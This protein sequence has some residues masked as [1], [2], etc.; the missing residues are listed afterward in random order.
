MTNE[1]AQQLRA[2]VESEIKLADEQRSLSGGPPIEEALKG[3]LRAELER[4]IA[5]AQAQDREVEVERRTQ[6]FR[7]YAAAAIVG[8]SGL[9]PDVP[10]GNEHVLTAYAANVGAAMIAAE[11]DFRDQQRAKLAETAK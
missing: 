1:E 5:Q 6:A 3:H 7:A 4:K 8:G 2:K 11:E 9:V 10:G